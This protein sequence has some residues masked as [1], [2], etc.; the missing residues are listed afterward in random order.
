MCGRGREEPHTKGGIWTK[1]YSVAVVYG[2]FTCIHARK[3]TADSTTLLPC[4]EETTA[5]RS[6]ARFYIVLCVCMNL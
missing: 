5:N 3:Q 6:L 1:N 2:L 4:T